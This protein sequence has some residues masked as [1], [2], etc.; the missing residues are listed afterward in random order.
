MPTD[1]APGS[2]TPLAPPPATCEGQHLIC[3]L[4]GARLLRDVAHITAAVRRA[5][6]AC[7]ATVLNVQ[8]HPFQENG[9][10]AG[11]ALLAESHITIHTWP[12]HAYAAIDVFMCG[13]CDPRDS[14]P[15]WE[16][17]FHPET[18]THQTLVRGTSSGS[19]RS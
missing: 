7:G 12:E 15:V 16:A 3:E 1:A 10:V 19:P 6:E 4:H 14:L 2:A 5:A 13:A 17:A 8:M 18:L 9:G 11:V